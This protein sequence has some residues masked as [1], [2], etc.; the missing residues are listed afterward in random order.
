MGSKTQLRLL[1]FNKINRIIF[2]I[3]LIA[4][5]ASNSNLQH[6]H[7]IHNKQH[8]NGCLCFNDTDVDFLLIVI[9]WL[10]LFPFLFRFYLLKTMWLLWLG[11]V[12]TCNMLFL[13]YWF[14]WCWITTMWAV[15]STNKNSLNSYHALNNLYHSHSLT[16]KVTVCSFLFY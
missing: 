5:Q 4:T 15:L 1:S 9:D 13:V 3:G 6:H 2:H 12:L 14:V 16:S 8:C 10:I 7:Y 11:P